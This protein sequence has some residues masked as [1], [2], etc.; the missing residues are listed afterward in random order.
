LNDKL[1]F[2]VVND[3]ILQAQTDIVALKYADSFYGADEIV[4]NAIGFSGHLQ[5]GQHAFIKGSNI[6]AGEVLFVG[7]GPLSNF[8]YEEIRAF[9]RLI[10]ERASND[11]PRATSLALTIHGPGYGLDEKEA[12]L[13]LMSGLYAAR[14]SR[15][16]RL[17]V[18]SIFERNQGRAKR[19]EQLLLVA[20]GLDGP[21]NTSTVRASASKVLSLKDYG[22]K[23]EAKPK[24]FVAMP[25]APE[26]LDEYEIAF[27]EAAHKN[28]FVCERLDLES[29]VGDVVSEIKNRILNSNGVIALLNGHNPNVFLEVG[30]AMA[31]SKPIIF[32]VHS[33][34]KVPFDVRGQ[35]YLKYERI[36]E[37][38][39]DLTSEISELKLAGVLDS[40]NQGTSGA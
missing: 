19:L 7:V 21:A 14:T 22:A 4:A 13:S 27:T 24:L 12:F 16:S 8:R 20:L 39:R 2:G 28:E 30:F 6:R 1:D 37:L 3:D 9:G 25:F 23:S 18:V 33:T 38:R 35:R 5:N 40:L 32:V 17:R 10:L 15:N 36:F 31:H 29:F 26:Y 34:T 11:R